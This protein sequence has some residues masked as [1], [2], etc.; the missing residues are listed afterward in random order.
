MIA[1]EARLGKKNVRAKIRRDIAR[2]VSACSTPNDGQRDV[3][4]NVSTAERDYFRQ[5]FPRP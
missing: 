4:T 3:T 2:Y 5:L 1:G